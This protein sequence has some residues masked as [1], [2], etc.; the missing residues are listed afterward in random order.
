VVTPR[1]RMSAPT[2]IPRAVWF[3]ILVTN[4]CTSCA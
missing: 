4:M 3:A 2:A 1:E